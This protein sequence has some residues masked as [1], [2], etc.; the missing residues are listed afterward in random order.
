MVTS[1]ARREVVRHLRQAW[2]SSERH[3]CEVTGFMRS[4]IRYRPRRGSDEVL[5]ERLRELAGRLTRAGYRTL[6]DQLTKAGVAVN[7][8]RVYRLYRDEG[9]AVRRR[10]RKHRAAGP[11]QPLVPAT[12]LNE[13]WPMDFIGDTLADGRAFRVL[14]ILDS[15]SRECL[16]L[17]VDHSLPAQRV[18]RILDRLA[19]SRDLPR[20]LV[21]DNGPEFRSHDLDVWATQRGVALHF[22][23]PGRPMENAFVESFHGKFRDECLNTH[24][25]ESLEDAQAT[26]ETWRC[27]YNTERGHSSLG[28]ATP[29]E[30]A[31]RAGL[32]A[33][34]RRSAQRAQQPLPSTPGNLS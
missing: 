2:G 30:F 6:H 19:L 34:P 10:S 17:E 12:E 32:R 14:S 29:F 23:R 4:V 33:S 11:R 8:K 9:L 18:T 21:M 20:T 7:H 25:F 27:W 13:R 1:A 31:L 26:I 22:V 24:W 3:G 5:R 15:F 28:R 16:A